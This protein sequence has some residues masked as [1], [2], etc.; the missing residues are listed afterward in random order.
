MNLSR[1]SNSIPFQ[2]ASTF[3]LC[4][5]LPGQDS[6]IQLT[7]FAFN[8]V[9]VWFAQMV[10]EIH[11]HGSVTKPNT[12]D[13]FDMEFSSQIWTIFALAEAISLKLTY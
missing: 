6:I 13:E 3:H 1:G 10:E 11:L 9:F 5:L 7:I 2:M 4:D 8:F 12:T